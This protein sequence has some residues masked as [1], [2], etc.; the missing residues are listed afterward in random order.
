MGQRLDERHAQHVPEVDA[1]LAEAH[2]QALDVADAEPAPNEIIQPDPVGGEV[3]TR[4]TWRER[5]AVARE[6]GQ[7]LRFD[8]GE[9]P[10]D[11]DVRR[12]VA[13]SRGVAV[14][15][16]ANAGDGADGEH[17][18]HRLALGR[19]DVDRLDS[20]R[21][22]G[23]Y[24]AVVT[25]VSTL[26]QAQTPDRDRARDRALVTSVVVVGMAGILAVAIRSLASDFDPEEIPRAVALPAL[27]VA[28]GLIGLLGARQSRPRVVAA[29]GILGVLSG[30]LSVITL[31][32]AIPGLLL[33]VLAPRMGGHERPRPGLETAT[34]I[35]VV[36]LVIGAGVAILGLSES[37]CWE[38]SGSVAS[39][40]YTWVTCTNGP[41][42]AGGT[43]IASGF[44]SGL[45]TPGGFG[46]EVGLLLL[47]FAL[48]LATGEP[49]RARSDHDLIGS[50]S[51]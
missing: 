1:R 15:L 9:A 17:R 33:I 41:L 18:P 12:I 30:L 5:D 36:M 7:D 46:A 42:S 51:T 43:T 3:A 47:A 35:I 45:L 8:Q 44:S 24:C 11:L 49:R 2:T 21:F 32:F 27:Y 22:H 10:P 34:A 28:I 4:G 26:P 31:A 48:L 16:Q 19:G 50:Q 38:A 13:G 37:R 14:A 23:S 29:A 39:P 6:V 25:A 20:A 40:T